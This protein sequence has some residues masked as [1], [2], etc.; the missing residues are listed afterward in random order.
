MR[1]ADTLGKAW[2]DE[3]FTMRAA[4]AASRSCRRAAALPRGVDCDPASSRPAYVKARFAGDAVA[5]S[6]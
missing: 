1:E 4:L 3:A 2:V 6:T 5:P